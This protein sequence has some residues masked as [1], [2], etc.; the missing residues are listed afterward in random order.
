[1]TAQIPFVDDLIKFGFSPL[2]SLL[3]AGIITLLLYIKNAFHKQ[4]T[5][6]IEWHNETREQV[7]QATLKVSELESKR[8]EDQAHIIECN[9][10]RQQLQTEVKRLV[11]QIG[12]F[13]R[14]PV[15]TCP[16]KRKT[17]YSL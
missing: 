10:H 6:R 5:M 9:Q 14:C 1:M 7:E 15:E 11:E 8:E 17:L 3:L 2:S 12:E 13:Q 16:N 4:E